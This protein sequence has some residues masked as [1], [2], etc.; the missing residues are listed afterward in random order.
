MRSFLNNPAYSRMHTTMLRKPI[1]ALQH[2][3]IQIAAY[4]Y[5]FVAS[6]LL[7]PVIA[8]SYVLVSLSCEKDSA[9]FRK[10]FSLVP[11]GW[12]CA[13][14]TTERSW[15]VSLWWLMMILLSILVLLADRLPLSG[16]FLL[17]LLVSGVV[18]GAF[19]IPLVV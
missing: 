2:K 9:Y 13:D 18:L 12:E 14:R 1:S 5:A 17:A 8:W 7:V 11:F 15:V 6:L 4:V 3:A 16:C 10:A 19:L